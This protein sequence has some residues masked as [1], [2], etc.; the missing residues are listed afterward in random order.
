MEI[1]SEFYDL[2]G[3][4]D[5]FH[6]EHCSYVL[7]GRT[8]IDYIIRDLIT[9]NGKVASVYLPDYCCDSMII[10]FLKNHIS[11]IF[12][13]TYVGE[14]GFQF[15]FDPNNQCEVV[16]LLDYFGYQI[17][18]LKKISEICKETGKIVI[19]DATH[20]LLGR[21]EIL[22][23]Y[24][25]CSFRKWFY[26]NAAV[27][28]KRGKFCIQPP[29]KLHE[30]YCDMRD[31]AAEMK[32]DFISGYISDKQ[33]FL[34]LFASAEELLDKDYECYGVKKIPE[35]DLNHITDRRKKNADVLMKELRNVKGLKLAVNTV[36]ERSCPLFVPVMLDAKIRDMVR[37][38]M[39][40]MK[41]YCPVHWPVT[42]YHRG[43]NNSIYYQEISLVCDQRYGEDDMRR[44]SLILKESL[45][46]IL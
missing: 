46:N 41:I 13:R 28:T 16:Y 15:L 34:S 27:V 17:E 38:R 35:Y 1:G 30:K 5:T 9:E 12:Y 7:S 11:V 45:E 4:R 25:F 43:V 37:K 42:T 18:E 8:A 44:E 31:H 14:N 24:A 26:S 40:E 20:M 6:D 39:I 32:R 21:N 29:S 19:Y 22:Y 3:E 2:T 10:P 36:N 33:G 23:D